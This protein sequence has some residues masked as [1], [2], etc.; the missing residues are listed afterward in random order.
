[1]ELLFVFTLL[2]VCSDQQTKRHSDTHTKSG[3]DAYIIQKQT[4]AHTDAHAKCA[5]VVSFLTPFIRLP[6]L[7]VSGFVFL[8]KEPDFGSSSDSDKKSRKD[9]GQRCHYK[10]FHFTIPQKMQSRPLDFTERLCV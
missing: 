6:G 1:M 9:P 8:M 2:N 10:I 4:K 5:V 7:F 3:E